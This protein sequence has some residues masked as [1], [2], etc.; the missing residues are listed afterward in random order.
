[1]KDVRILKDIFYWELI[2]GKRNFEH[3]QL[4]YRDAC[5]RDMKELNSDLNKWEELATD[6]S[7]WSSYT[8]ITVKFFKKKINDLENKCK[9]KNQ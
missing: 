3:P 6:L 9:L 4:L 5:K 7:K 2:A 1:M 8:Q